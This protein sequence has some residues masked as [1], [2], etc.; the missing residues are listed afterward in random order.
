MT[1]TQKLIEAAEQMLIRHDSEI[2]AA[3]WLFSWIQA[4]N[5]RTALAAAK[6]EKPECRRYMDDAPGVRAECEY[7]IA[8]GN[9]CFDCPKQEQQ[10][11]PVAWWRVSYIAEDGSQDADVQIGPNKPTDQMVPPN[12]HEWE[13][14]FRPPVQQAA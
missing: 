6:Q 14:L 12:G 2:Y 13:P 8:K 7:Q 10:A 11:E 4:D 5:L 3:P 9:R 1:P